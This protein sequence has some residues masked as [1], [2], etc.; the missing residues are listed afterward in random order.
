MR[1]TNCWNYLSYHSE[2][3]HIAYSCYS[4]DPCKYSG[5]SFQWSEWYTIHC[6]EFCKEC[7][8]WSQ[9]SVRMSSLTIIVLF[10]EC[11]SD[12]EEWWTHQILFTRDLLYLSNLLSEP[13]QYFLVLPSLMA[14]IGFVVIQTS[15][16]PVFR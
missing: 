10:K 7:Y 8:E 2:Y 9:C 15:H 6:P 5:N 13:I 11:F 16:S 12:H 1:I 4:D 3:A 14:V